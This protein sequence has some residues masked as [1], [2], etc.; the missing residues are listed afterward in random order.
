VLLG[1]YILHRLFLLYNTHT[2]T[3]TFPGP[4]SLPVEYAYHITCQKPR[5]KHAVAFVPYPEIL[6][7]K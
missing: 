1:P 6:Y 2:H 5:R 7:I 3:Y 4:H